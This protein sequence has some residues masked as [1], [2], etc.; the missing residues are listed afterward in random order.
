MDPPTTT[1]AG[2]R[3]QATACS[4]VQRCP[5]GL[6]LES[7]R[8]SS[9]AMGR[10][11][12][13]PKAPLKPRPPRRARAGATGA[14]TG[15]SS[16]G[17]APR[18]AL[19]GPRR[20]PLSWARALPTLGGLALAARGRPLSVPGARGMSARGGRGL[21]A[22]RRL[23]RRPVNPRLNSRPL[24]SRDGGCGGPVFLSL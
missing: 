10:G 2:L 1:S 24:F 11:F 23:P 7:P 16:R 13:P 22:A 3:R 4:E 6:E 21:E 8:P 12:L 18:H 14:A 9:R 17:A 19:G 20:D 15:T 5:R